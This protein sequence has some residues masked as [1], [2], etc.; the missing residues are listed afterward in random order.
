MPKPPKKPSITPRQRPAKSR[1][2]AA[3]ANSLFAPRSF[4]DVADDLEAVDKPDEPGDV[5]FNE[6]DLPTLEAHQ[7]ARFHQYTV[8]ML[9]FAVS[10]AARARNEL[11]GVSTALTRH[12]AKLRVVLGGGKTAKWEIDDQVVLDEHCIKLTDEH[13][14]KKAVLELAEAECKV[15]EFREKMMSRE[16]TRRTKEFEARNSQD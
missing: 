7:L 3:V 6:F 10:Y 9:A 5:T 16:L 14:I 1:V 11:M 4:D 12:K 8:G 15:W 2:S 13:D